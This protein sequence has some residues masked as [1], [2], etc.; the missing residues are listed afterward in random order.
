MKKEQISQQLNKLSFPKAVIGNLQR[1][2]FSQ[3]YGNSGCVEDPRLQAS[4]MTINLN[5]FPSSIFTGHFPPHGEAAHF[6]AP[7]TWRKRAKCI[8]TGVRGKIARGFT[9]IELLVVILIIGILAVVALPQYQLTV[10][11]SRYAILK[12]L[13]RSIENAQEVYYLANGQYASKFAD[14]DIEMPSG[15]LN[16]STDSTYKYD[17]GYCTM[18]GSGEG[19]M[20]ANAA[21]SMQYQIHHKQGEDRTTCLAFSMD[22]NDINNKICKNETGRITYSGRSTKGGYTYWIYP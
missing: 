6:N 7:S 4:G 2:S 9:L 11:K 22:E 19:T 18:G 14:L 16:T 21:I 17:W 1:L 12:T 20:C 13:A 3:A 5:V 15:K 10:A 8:S